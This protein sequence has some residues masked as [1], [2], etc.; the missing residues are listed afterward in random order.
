MN[1]HTLYKKLK[2]LKY[3]IYFAFIIQVHHNCESRAKQNL[4]PIDLR[5]LLGKIKNIIA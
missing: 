1:I 5:N 3:W 2:Y 4:M